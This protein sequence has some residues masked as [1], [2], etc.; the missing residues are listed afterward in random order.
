MRYFKGEQYQR[1]FG[2]G[3]L[4]KRFFKWVSPYVEKTLPVIKDG[5][6]HVGKEVVNSAASIA[7]DV[8]EGKNVHESSK[9]HLNNSIDNL[10]K[11]A[12]ESMAGRG[13]KRKRQIAKNSHSAK[14]KK[15]FD[16]FS[17]K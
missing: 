1:G 13:Y 14:K 4:F 6:K 17:K 9:S 3:S 11:M 10:K 2:L 8:I 5:L 7:K 15:Y 16:L 12:D